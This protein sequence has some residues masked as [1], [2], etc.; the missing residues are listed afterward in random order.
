[1]TLR[2]LIAT[3]AFVAALGALVPATSS[4]LVQTLVSKGNG[5]QIVLGGGLV[6]GKLGAGGELIV[7]DLSQ[8]RDL[9][10]TVL[11]PSSVKK[12]LLITGATEWKVK[13]GHGASF[14]V[15][16]NKFRLQAIGAAQLNGVPVYG[17]ASFTGT[18]TYSINGGAPQPWAGVLAPVDLGTPKKPPVGSA[19]IH[20]PFAPAR[21]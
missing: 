5:H 17:R 9:K 15:T 1:V 20:T 3:F 7:N 11:P 14:S 6:Y 16:G 21:R 4:A 10:V 19:V 18:G 8:R 2:R 13:P 12:I